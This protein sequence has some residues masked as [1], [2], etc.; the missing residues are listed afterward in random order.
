MASNGYDTAQHGQP[1]RS[2][3]GL[4]AQV[5][6][7]CAPSAPNPVLTQCTVLSHCLE[8]CLQDFSKNKNK[9]KNKKIKNQMK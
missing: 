5:G 9:N 7:G 2:V 3:R 6:P 1:G 8:H 4:G